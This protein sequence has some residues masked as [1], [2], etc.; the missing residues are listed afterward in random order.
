MVLIL[1]TV[2]VGET[3]EL[4]ARTLVDERLAACV[5]LFPPMTSV[6]RWRGA[7]EQESERQLVIKT[8][9]ERL[10]ALRS[11]LLALH[12]YDLPEF[13]VVEAAAVSDAYLA[14][15]RENTTVA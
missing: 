9:R 14:W 5:N 10:P 11:R 12:P 7:V 3:A 1:T 2:P 13:V 8:S 6:Y 15:V 4:M